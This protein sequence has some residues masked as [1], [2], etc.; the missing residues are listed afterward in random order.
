MYPY[1]IVWD[2]PAPSSPLGW[3]SGK[4]PQLFY[5]GALSTL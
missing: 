1:Y 2:P 4:A 5:I 3:G